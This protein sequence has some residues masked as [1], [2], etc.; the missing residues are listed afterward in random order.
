MFKI[1]KISFVFFTLI[2]ILSCSKKQPEFSGK[3]LTYTNTQEGYEIDYP[4]EILKPLESSPSEQVFASN[5]G[6]VS[7]SVSVSDI[8]ETGPD[9]IFK[10]ADLYEKKESEKFTVSDKNMGRD[11]FILKGYSKDKMFFCQALAINEKFYKIRFEYN[12]KDYDTYRDILTHI[13][14]SFELTSAVASHNNSYDEGKLISFAFSFLSNVYWENNFNLLLKNSSSK[15][16]DFVHPE[17]GVRRFYNPGTTVRLFSAEENF[18]F[19]ESTDF[20]TI[21][22]ANKFGGSIPFYDKMPDGGLC[23]ESNDKDGVYCVI[24]QELPTAVDPASFESDEIKNLKIELPN[25]YKAIL[26]ILIL[27]EGFIKKTFYFFDIEDKWF[28][29]F[30]DDCDC[31]A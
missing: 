20:S 28:L 18:G 21:P 10:T 11:G 1:K 22:S 19:D 23:E 3:Y 8:E 16:A 29:F 15:L 7:L 31:S 9:F 5:D 2:F 27:N 14:D 26:K 4:S 30:V 13:I 25:D 24:V 17:Y 6:D 12:K